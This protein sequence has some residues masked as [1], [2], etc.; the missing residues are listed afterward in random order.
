[1]KPSEV[2]RAVESL[3]LGQLKELGLQD[4]TVSDDELVAKRSAD[5]EELARYIESLAEHYSETEDTGIAVLY[6]QALVLYATV[7]SQRGLVMT[8]AI[9]VGQHTEKGHGKFDVRAELSMRNESEG[10]GRMLVPDQSFVIAISLQSQVT[11]KPQTLDQ[12]FL[13][14]KPAAQNMVD[15]SVTPDFLDWA[16][17][18]L[19]SA[20]MPKNAPR[21]YDPSVIADIDA[22]NEYGLGVFAPPVVDPLSDPR[23]MITHLK[24]VA[25]DRI[26]A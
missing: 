14:R 2:S 6:A 26:A 24:Q 11:G 23:H 7:T 25:A 19:E 16:K 20:K 8:E 5:M 15:T 18:M 21:M 12:Q 4:E 22:R 1:M 10:E 3:T 17:L 9:K 13:R